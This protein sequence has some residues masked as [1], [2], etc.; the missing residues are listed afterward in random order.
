LKFRRREGLT[1]TDLF[2]DEEIAGNSVAVSLAALR[3]TSCGWEVRMR[4][5]RPERYLRCQRIG[6]KRG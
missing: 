3:E 6:V 2:V 5:G 1:A 4:S